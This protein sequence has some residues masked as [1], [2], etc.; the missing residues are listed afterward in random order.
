[1]SAS[2]RSRTT[3]GLFMLALSLLAVLPVLLP[4]GPPSPSRATRQDAPF[5]R[6]LDVDDRGDVSTLAVTPDGGHAL[7]AV[8]GAIH[9]LDIPADL[10]PV[11]GQSGRPTLDGQLERVLSIDATPLGIA[12]DGGDA[13][14]AAGTQ[15]LLRVS[16]DG[17]GPALPQV[18][19]EREG[20]ACFDTAILELPG[21]QEVLLALF[22]GRAGNELQVLLRGGTTWVPLPAARVPLPSGNL[23]EL[24]DPELDDPIGYTLCVDPE[25]GRAYVAMGTGGI[26]RVDFDGFASGMAPTALPP[27]VALAPK[28]PFHPAN[29]GFHINN[30]V[31]EQ[32]RIRDLCIAGNQLLATV[33]GKGV[34]NFS[35]RSDTWPP[36]NQ[37][38]IFPLSF[39]PE[40]AEPCSSPFL[41]PFHSFAVRIESVELPSERG[42]LVFVRGSFEPVKAAS[43]GLPFVHF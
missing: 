1:M 10:T 35:L 21:G 38:Q 16:W 3:D 43:E 20:R 7:V 23:L 6:L 32:G 12:I 5:A 40:P 11:D 36:P 31:F 27:F 42:H 30:P 15:G 28:V 37:D 29:L 2:F 33:D 17:I 34:A 24:E 39:R 41:N 4:S 25:R 22:S 18:V 26:S 8:G 19:L 14:V 13:I 9:V